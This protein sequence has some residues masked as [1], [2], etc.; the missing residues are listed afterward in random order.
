[1]RFRETHMVNEQTHTE[2]ARH[3]HDHGD[4]IT[5]AKRGSK[6]GVKIEATEIFS[7]K[8]ID[9]QNMQSS[10]SEKKKP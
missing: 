9:G 7:S 6:N 8:Q 2:H 1:M 5:C 4:G 10:K 3:K